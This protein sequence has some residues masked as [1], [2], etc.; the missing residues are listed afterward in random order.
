MKK[1]ILV[2]TG[3]GKGKTT[4]AIGIVIRFRGYNKKVGFFKFFKSQLSGEDKIL[5]K[6]GVRIF[7]FKKTQF[8]NPQKVPKKLID[9]NIVLWQK[10]LKLKSQFDL[11]ILDEISLALNAHIIRKDNFIDFAKNSK[12]ILVCTGRAAPIWL[13]KIADTVSEIKNIKHNFDSNNH[14]SQKGIEY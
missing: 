14:T 13:K 6:L 9:E 7:K 2:I 4:A 1:R 8:F 10:V 12:A 5:K 3:N 11:I